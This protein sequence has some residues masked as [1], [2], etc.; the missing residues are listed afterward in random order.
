M[1]LPY[2]KGFMWVASGGSEHHS[3][4]LSGLAEE[5]SAANGLNVVG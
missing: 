3:K 5:V 4:R 2:G 1:L